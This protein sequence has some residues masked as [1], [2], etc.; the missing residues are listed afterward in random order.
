MNRSI[1]QS[2]GYIENTSKIT[3]RFSRE[4]STSTRLRFMWNGFHIVLII[5][6]ILFSVSLSDPF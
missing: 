6:R 4:G 3:I 1:T 2:A 5:Y